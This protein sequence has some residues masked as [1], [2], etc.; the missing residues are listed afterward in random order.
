MMGDQALKNQLFRW[1]G[2]FASGALACALTLGGASALAAEGGPALSDEPVPMLTDEQMPQRVPPLLEIGGDFLGTG[3]IP[4][5]F[6]LPTGAVWIPQLWVF[7][8]V[9]SALNL[10]EREDGLQDVAEW[11]TRA[12]I[13]FNLKLSATERFLLQLTPLHT[14]N[15]WT[16][17]EF[18]DDFR[19]VEQ[20]NLQI[21]R[22]FFEADFGEIFP[23][24]DPEDRDALDWG[25][26]VGRQPIF[27][28]EGIM[29][30]DIMDAVALVR[31]TI[32]FDSVID[33]RVTGLYA[34]N[35]IS[36]DDNINDNG[37]DLFGLFVE[38]DTR[39]STLNFDAAYVATRERNG[40]DSLNLA[41]SGVQRIL[42]FNTALRVNQSFAL[43]DESRQSD[44]GT[45]FFGEFSFTPKSTHDLAYL[46]AF[47]GID[48][49]RSAAR[50]EFAGGPL[51]RVGL[52]F[53]APAIGRA[54]APLGN[55][56]DE[57]FGGAIGYQMF[58]NDDATQVV[59]EV[60]FIESSAPAAMVQD[61]VGVGLRFQHKF[62]DRFLVQ[63][64]GFYTNRE[65]DDDTVGGRAELVVQF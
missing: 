2:L 3:N 64:D 53:A 8:N 41:I 31:D 25:F 57:S 21:S 42:G 60:G 58:F 59:G 14:R 11:I 43:D 6:E 47:V 5:G 49:F 36:R 28:Q 30:N 27:F 26:A 48:E 1:Q 13:N 35:R 20:T 37:A 44:D 65:I 54:P 10:V 16:G 34:W 23:D 39:W 51:G 40:G 9:R 7:G 24:L 18:E 38:T 56:V 29:I 12:D 15:G 22:L 62:L 4:Q 52:L 19:D 32:I 17:F 45:L 46:N 33:T 61:G 55:R 63:L 50:D